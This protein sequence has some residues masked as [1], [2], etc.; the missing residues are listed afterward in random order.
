VV[1]EGGGASLLGISWPVPWL[2]GLLKASWGDVGMFLGCLGALLESSFGAG[3]PVSSWVSLEGLSDA[4]RGDLG[5]HWALLTASWEPLGLNLGS[6]GE[7]L[8][9]H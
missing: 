4:S 3:P 7:V 9:D 5:D 1:E 6:P 8:G 2:G